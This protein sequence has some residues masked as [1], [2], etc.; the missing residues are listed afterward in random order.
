MLRILAVVAALCIAACSPRTVSGAYVYSSPTEVAMLQLVEGENG[1]LSG[2]L[3]TATANR[4]FQVNVES[5]GLS[6]TIDGNTLTLATPT[7][8]GMGTTFSGERSG[9]EIT[10]TFTGR[11][12]VNSITFRRSTPDEFARLTEELRQ[13]QGAQAEERARQQAAAQAQA[14]DERMR[15]AIPALSAELEQTAA[16]DVEMVRRVDGA[17]S[18]FATLTQ[19]ARDAAIQRDRE[20]DGVRQSQI[21]VFISQVSVETTQLNIEVEQAQREFEQHRVSLRDQA[22]RATAW[23]QR[24]RDAVCARLATAWQSYS[25][26][27]D[28]LAAAF[29]RASTA[30]QR[31]EA[32]QSTL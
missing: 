18:Q 27:S 4:S 17:V 26:E 21:S 5:V 7:F 29:A 12:N 15:Q 3:Q 14:A 24:T 10:L 2:S 9:N 8:L 23:C 11:S 13:G 1:S 22:G 30:H 6:G 28:A 32:D 19:R 20:R 16:N 25:R 31:A